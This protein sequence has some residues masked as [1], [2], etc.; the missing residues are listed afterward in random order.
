MVK[1][2]IGHQYNY[3]RLYNRTCIANIVARV[4]ARH[5][6]PIDD[7]SDE[8]EDDGYNYRLSDCIVDWSSDKWEK[9]ITQF[10]SLRQGLLRNDAAR[11]VL[12]AEFG[13]EDKEEE[14]EEDDE[15]PA[16]DDS[17]NPLLESSKEFGDNYTALLD[18]M[19]FHMC[20]SHIR[21]P[22]FEDMMK[23]GS[24]GDE[25]KAGSPVFISHDDTVALK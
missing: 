14:E 17:V 13:D 9:I 12:P 23:K 20:L 16:Q 18:L 25:K 4:C 1:R 15:A 3:G 21:S 22:Q 6:Y 8:E 7:N 10:E 19:K 11:L 24:D 5:P 2:L